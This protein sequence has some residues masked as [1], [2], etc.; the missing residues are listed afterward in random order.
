M[1][2]HDAEGAIADCLRA[3][4]LEPGSAEIQGLAGFAYNFAGQNELAEQYS[5]NVLDLS[6]MPA[7]WHYLENGQIEIAKGNLEK[8][9]ELLLQGLAVEPDSPVCRFY[10]V[11]LMLKL[12]NETAAKQY[13]DEIHALHPSINGSGVVHSHSIDADKRA[14]FRASLARFDL[15]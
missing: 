11:D 6:P 4:E 5:S 1:M 9:T 2:R 14:A 13:A 7:G 15:I 12:G 3:V 10:L 8:A